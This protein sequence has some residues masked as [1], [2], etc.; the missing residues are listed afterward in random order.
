[1]SAILRIS[2]AEVGTRHTT[3]RVTLEEE[4]LST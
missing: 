3:E 1:V 4:S 2:E